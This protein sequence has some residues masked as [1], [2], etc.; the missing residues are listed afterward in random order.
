M[1]IFCEKESSSII[2]TDFTAI[3]I[4]ARFE[5]ALTVIK[6]NAELLESAVSQP[7]QDYASEILQASH[8]ME[9]Y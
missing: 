2:R 5:D 7:L 6:G 9:E 4:I 8:K 3:S 1:H